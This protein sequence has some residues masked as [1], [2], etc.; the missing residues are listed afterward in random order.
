MWNPASLLTITEIPRAPASHY[1]N[2]S[3]SLTPSQ[4]QV[5]SITSDPNKN[6]I[7]ISVGDSIYAFG[8]FSIWQNQ[9]S[10]IS[11]TYKGKSLALGQIA[12]DYLSNNLYWC[13]SLLDWIAMKPAYTNNETIYK[14]IVDKDLKQPEGIALDPEDGYDIYKQMT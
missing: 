12:F 7:F 11:R 4:A 5:T 13:D 8:N 6:I 3:Q 14:V 2:T 1:G 9:T 10:T